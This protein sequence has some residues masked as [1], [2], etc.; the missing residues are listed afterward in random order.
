MDWNTRVADWSDVA[1]TDPFRRLADAVIA[2]ASPRADDRAIDLG[3]GTGLLTLR[4]ADC[5]ADVVGIDAAPAMVAHL[6]DACRAEDRANVTC[7]VADLRA[8]P[9]PDASRTLAVSNYAFHHLDHEGKRDGVHEVFRVLAPGGRV[10]ISDMMFGLSLRSGDRRI[11]AGKV[12]LMAKKG[13]A[14]LVRLARNGFRILAGKWEHPE[15][16]DHWIDLLHEAGFVDV[17]HVSLFNEAGL[18]TAT[19]PKPV[20]DDGLPAGGVGQESLGVSP[21]GGV[22]RGRPEHPA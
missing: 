11:I 1:A 9:V 17:N 6:Q 3:C 19:R 8:L 5:V 13:P 14:G 7:E 15:P 16:P 12:R 2:A 18:V 22:V 4:L 21:G 10:V 20:N